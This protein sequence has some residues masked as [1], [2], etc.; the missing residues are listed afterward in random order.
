MPPK[1]AHISDL[2]RE[3]LSNL[4]LERQVVLIKLR[5]FIV[6]L[7]SE[8]LSHT[9][10]APLCPTRKSVSKRERHRVARSGRR[11]RI[12][13]QTRILASVHKRI[14]DSQLLSDW[15]E[16]LKAIENTGATANNRALVKRPVS[17][18]YPWTKVVLVRLDER[19]W[20]FRVA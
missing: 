16:C 12:L 2:K 3:V 15:I 7:Q 19:F 18:T 17:K 5:L 9:L 1:R 13:K 10:L 4:P 11:A 20:K 6:H 8:R 14:R